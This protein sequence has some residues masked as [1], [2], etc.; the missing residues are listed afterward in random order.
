MKKRLD[1]K[2]AIVTGAAS[3]APGLGTGKAI[4]F[5]FAREGAKVIAIN[6]NYDKAL[7]LQEE[8]TAEGGECF[9]YSADVTQ[10][11]QVEAM[12][13]EVISRFGRIDVLVNNVGGGKGGDGNVV[14]ITESAWEKLFDLN[15]KTAM[16]ASKY[17]IPAMIKGGGGSII[18]ISS[19]AAMFGGQVPNSGA[20]GYITSKT[21]LEGLTKSMAADF[22]T[23]LVRVNSIVVGTVWTP[24][25]A[26]LGIE[27]RERLKN[28]VPL[29]TEGTA[30]DAAW[31]A[32]YLACDESKWVTGVS[33]PVDGGFLNVRKMP[34]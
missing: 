30:W 13:T 4:C 3:Q 10:A 24:M 32:V 19:I 7:E 23:D 31:A 16:I 9:A 11:V 14:Q 27:A 15:L 17:C 25:A 21:A 6:R 33:L 1:G 12:I 5:L 18:N 29:K 8:I 34:I 20:A 26:N 28:N 2:V 22:A